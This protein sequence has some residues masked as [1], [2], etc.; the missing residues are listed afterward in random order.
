[1]SLIGTRKLKICSEQITVNNLD[2][3]LL[4]GANILQFIPVNSPPFGVILFQNSNGSLLFI[5]QHSAPIHV[6]TGHL[7]KKIPLGPCQAEYMGMTKR[8]RAVMWIRTDTTNP[9]ASR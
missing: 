1:M 7:K 8:V 3:V 2:S 5:G 9:L 6:Q 4:N